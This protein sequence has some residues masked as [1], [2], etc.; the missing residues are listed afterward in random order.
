MEERALKIKTA[1]AWKDSELATARAILLE[2]SPHQVDAGHKIG[3]D[4]RTV[5]VE[6]YA[7]AGI[8]GEAILQVIRAKCMDCCVEQ[9]DEVRKCTAITCPNWPYRMGSNPFRAKRQLS[10]EQRTALVERLAASRGATVSAPQK[11]RDGNLPDDLPP[12]K[13]L[14]DQDHG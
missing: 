1:D 10:D 7:R 11:F 14:E 4:P 5:S 9:A 2:I 3:R 13:G 12:L 8:E 6:D